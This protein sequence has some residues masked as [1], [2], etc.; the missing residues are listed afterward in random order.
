M[1]LKHSSK[2]HLAAQNNRTYSQGKINE[3]WLQQKNKIKKKVW[4]IIRSNKSKQCLPTGYMFNLRKNTLVK[5]VIKLTR[6]NKVRKTKMEAAVKC[7]PFMPIQ[8]NM[9]RFRKW[10]KNVHLVAHESLLTNSLYIRLF[11]NFQFLFQNTPVSVYHLKEKE[12]DVLV[13]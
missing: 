5:C 13:T 8:I 12:F 9:T 11:L 6:V 1:K 3:T 10:Q 7:E 4:S 2:G